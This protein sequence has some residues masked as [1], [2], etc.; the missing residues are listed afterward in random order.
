VRGGRILQCRQL[1][2]LL[3]RLS[4]QRITLFNQRLGRALGVEGKS[5][6]DRFLQRSVYRAFKPIDFLND[7]FLRL[8]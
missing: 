7:L 4:G 1:G 5:M 2:N 6:A 8:V 3:Q